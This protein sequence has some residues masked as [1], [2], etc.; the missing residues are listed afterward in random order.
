MFM[1][2]E[3]FQVLTRPLAYPEPNREQRKP[4]NQS[5]TGSYTGAGA[6]KP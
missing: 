5:H 4:H 3:A 1:A 6:L 2:P